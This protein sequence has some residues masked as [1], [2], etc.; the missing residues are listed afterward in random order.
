MVLPGGDVGSNEGL[1]QLAGG[2]RRSRS[3]KAYSFMMMTAQE[4]KNAELICRFMS[5]E[6]LASILIGRSP[7]KT[8]AKHLREEADGND[9]DAEALRALADELDPG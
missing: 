5:D 4:K 7:K 6:E 8:L 9:H 3:F 1:R 2:Q